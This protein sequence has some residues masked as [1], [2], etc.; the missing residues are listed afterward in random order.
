MTDEKSSRLK[1]AIENIRKDFFNINESI[2]KTLGF[3]C[4]FILMKF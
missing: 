1:L 4:L 2:S 3:T